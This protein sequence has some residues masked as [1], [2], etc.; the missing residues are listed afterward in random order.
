[1]MALLSILSLLVLTYYVKDVKADGFGETST[2][3]EV[4]SFF[5]E[6]DM[7]GQSPLYFGTQDV[8]RRRRVKR[9]RRRKV[10]TKTKKTS[11]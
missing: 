4:N 2:S 10:R 5:G 9:V 8:V 1:M 11:S 6:E 3:R 7:N